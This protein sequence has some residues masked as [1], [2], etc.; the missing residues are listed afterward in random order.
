MRRGVVIALALL[1]VAAWATGATAFLGNPTTSDIAPEQETSPAMFELETGA[2][3]Y[4]Y[5][6]ASPHTFE[7]RSAINVVVYGSL[8]ETVSVLT[9]EAAWLETEEDEQ[10]AGPDTYSAAE[11]DEAAEDNPLGWGYAA[12]AERFAFVGYGEE[13]AWLEESVQLHDGEYYGTRYHLRLYELPGDEPAVAIQAHHEHFDWFTLRHAVDSIENAQSHVEADL[14]DQLG[15]ENVIRQWVGND[16][17]YDSDG[18]VTFVTLAVLPVLL[19]L[20][21]V[22]AARHRID[23]WRSS[24]LVV[25]AEDR[26]GVEHASLFVAMVGIVLGVRYFGIVL[27]GTGWFTMH[28][29][30]GMLYPVMALGLPLTAYVLARSIERRMDAAMAA[31]LG[32]ASG[33]LL[34]YLQLGITVLPIELII[35]RTGLV[36]AIGLIAAG[37]STRA[38]TESRLN[39]FVAA[40]GVLWFV[41]LAL[42]LSAV[43]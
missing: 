32:L 23:R 30:A 15:H 34:D 24:D 6:S 25:A 27:E 18:W 39:P 13:T 12:G 33:V 3:I 19:G 17:A 42:A 2:E 40:G 1:L 41:L 29:I 9:D 7:Q 14:M 43:I 20:G 31:S 26:F 5:Y 37:A 8:D 21:A 35:H 16:G 4:P 28:T 38:R 22:T 36:V 10:D 11:L